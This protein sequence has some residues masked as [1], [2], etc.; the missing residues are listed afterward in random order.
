MDNRVSL[1]PPKTLHTPEALPAVSSVAAGFVTEIR[2]PYAKRRGAGRGKAGSMDSKG[3][4][5]VH[6]LGRD[7]P[8]G[9]ACAGTLDTDGGTVKCGFFSSVPTLIRP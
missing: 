9:K 7:S 2:G 5:E 4:A 1:K 6:P 8:A 3:A